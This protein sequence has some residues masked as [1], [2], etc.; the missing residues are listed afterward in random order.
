[1]FLKDTRHIPVSVLLL[2]SSQTLCCRCLQ[3]E[4]LDLNILYQGIDRGRENSV[5]S[6]SD[7]PIR[8]FADY[9]II[10]YFNSNIGRYR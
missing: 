3:K 1:M 6:T 8:D 2:Q 5:A 7:A 4:Q 10:R 9:P